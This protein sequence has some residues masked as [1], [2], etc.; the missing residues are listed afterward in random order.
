MTKHKIAYAGS[1]VALMLGSGILSPLGAFA[2]GEKPFCIEGGECYE[3]LQAAFDAVP[4]DGTLT[5]IYLDSTDN[6]VEDGGGAFY[7]Y[8]KGAHP[9]N[10]NYN[11]VFDLKGKTFVVNR[12]AVG[13]TGY[14]TQA[15]HLEKGGKFVMKDGIMKTTATSGVKMI[16]QN[17]AD[18]T[19]DN[20]TLDASDTSGVTYTASNNFG[21]LTVKGD[22][23]ILASEGNVAF[24]IWYG[25]ASVYYGGISVTFGEDFTGKVN[26][27]IEYGCSSS[28]GGCS[29]TN[30]Q[31]KAKLSIAN[32]TFETS[33]AEGSTGA[34]DG[35]N[36]VI[37]GGTFKEEPKAEYIAKGCKAFAIDNGYIVLPLIT[38]ITLGYGDEEV[39]LYTRE[40]QILTISYVP[41]GTPVDFEVSTN[42]PELFMEDSLKIVESNGVYAVSFIARDEGDGE[43]VVTVTEKNSGVSASVKV[44]VVEALR[45]AD[46]VAED[47]TTAFVGFKDPVEGENLGMKIVNE[48]MTT[49]EKT[50]ISPYLKAVYDLNVVNQ[51]TGEVVPVSDN[52]IEVTLILKKADYEGMKYF[53]AGFINDEG[54]LVETFDAEANYHEDEGEESEYFALTFTTT[55]FST[56]GILASATEFPEVLTPDTGVLTANDAST[57]LDYGGLVATVAAMTVMTVAMEIVL[58]KRNQARK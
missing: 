16:L 27:K 9:A 20:V 21:S 10:N 12:E 31:K 22:S 29:E 51:T 5:T 44:K 13:S 33:F 42:N 26:G 58:W 1:A 28:G 4:N 47:G 34:L 49:E 41:E 54:K 14:E 56:Y 48:E 52:E 57:M 46:A 50:K 2:E 30:W 24:D 38:E 11:V 23:N 43:G 53:K 40:N 7:E 37:S 8:G 18:T 15:L 55:H 17:Y 45:S 6:I 25:M 39:E 19:L 35:A 3:T 36:I 32:G